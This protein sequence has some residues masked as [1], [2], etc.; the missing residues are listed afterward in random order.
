MLSLELSDQRPPDFTRGFLDQPI[1]RGREQDRS[2]HDR[3]TALPGAASG[4]GQVE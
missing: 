2:K 3:W 4:I 1:R